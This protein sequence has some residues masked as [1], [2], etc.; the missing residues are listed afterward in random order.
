MFDKTD[1]NPNKKPNKKLIFIKIYAILHLLKKEVLLCLR[2]RET[3]SH[4][5]EKVITEEKRKE[6]SKEGTE[7]LPPLS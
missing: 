4:T 3:K 6:I 2:I 5:R 1:K 7:L